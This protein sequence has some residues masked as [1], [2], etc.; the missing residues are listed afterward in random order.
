M[1]MAKIAALEVSRG[2][3]LLFAHVMERGS[4]AHPYVRSPLL[5][6]GPAAEANLA[7]AIHFLCTLHARYPSI[8]EMAQDRN[9]DS[10]AG[11]WFAAAS[12]A[13]TTERNLLAKLVVTV[14]PLPATPG[15]GASDAMALGQ[16]RAITLLAQSERRGCGLGAALALA[17]D[18]FHIRHV[19]NAAALHFGIVPPPNRFTDENAVAEVAHAAMENPAVERALL[20]GAE[21][22]LLQHHGLWGVLEARQLARSER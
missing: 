7:D 4:V 1:A 21:Q 5:S 17:L 15:A 22:I 18:W 14:G 9:A 2:A 16:Q 10:L 6:S 19:L 13:F 3:S 11:Q 8:I 20:F 12:R